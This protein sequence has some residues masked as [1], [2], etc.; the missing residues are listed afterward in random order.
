MLHS[1]ATSSYLK[2]VLVNTD[3]DP[4]TAIKITGET[5]GHQDHSDDTSINR[6]MIY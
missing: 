3:I 4:N 2:N 5:D 1:L 6:L